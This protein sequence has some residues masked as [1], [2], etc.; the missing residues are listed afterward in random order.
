MKKAYMTPAMDVRAL[1][2]ALEVFSKH[3]LEGFGYTQINYTNR[4][5]DS[6][7]LVL[8][9]NNQKLWVECKAY[10]SQAVSPYVANELLKTIV[11]RKMK[12][13]LSQEDVILLIVSSNIPSFQKDEI[14]KRHRIVVWDIENL[15]FLNF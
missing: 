13:N 7:D 1:G 12:Q 14:Y 4:E 5:H 8:Q 2:P 3:L 9:N 6:W 15:V 10:K 11:M